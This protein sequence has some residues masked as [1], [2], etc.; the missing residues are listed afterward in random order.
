MIFD[1]YL[2]GFVR[3]A[4]GAGSGAAAGG[5][6]Q[7]APASGAA[8]AGGGAAPA[9]GGAAQQGGSQASGAGDQGWWRGES[10]S[11]LDADT[12]KFLDGK[13][14]PDIKTALTSLRSA[15]QMARD[16]NVIRKPDPA[17]VQKWDGFAELGWSPEIANY[18]LTPP[19]AADGEVHDEKA[20]EAFLPAAHEARLLPWQAEAVYSAMH[21]HDN[22]IIGEFKAAAD[23]ANADLDRSLR[24]KFG[25]QYDAKVSLAKRAFAA[26]SPSE[27]VAAQMDSAFSSAGMVDLFVKIGEAMGEDRLVTGHGGDGG[28]VSVETL[29]KK[30]NTLW[31]DKDWKAAFDDPRNPRHKD[32]RDERANLLQR[33]AELEL[34]SR[35]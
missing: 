31:A 26:F 30:L 6:Q 25:N 35:K 20:W 3:E 28:A 24:A 11:G 29:Q 19:A 14:Y 10:Y 27:A 4:E 16:R 32:V 5:G 13:N 12:M 15:D 17:N 7:S 1:K 34:K 2:C 18:K 9:G 21:K 33:K 23:Q 22:A 8:P